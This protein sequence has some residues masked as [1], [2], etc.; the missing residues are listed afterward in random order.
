MLGILGLGAI[1]VQ[2]NEII[3]IYF[4]SFLSSSILIPI[5]EVDMQIK[6]GV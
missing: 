4:F 2:V 1:F 3:I 6:N 5:A